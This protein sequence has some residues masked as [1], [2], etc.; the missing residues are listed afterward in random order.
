MEKYIASWNKVNATLIQR[1]SEANTF[2]A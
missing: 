2:E 1:L